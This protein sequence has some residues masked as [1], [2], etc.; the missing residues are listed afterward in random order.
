MEPGPEADNP[1]AIGPAG[2]VHATLADWGKYV[3]LHVAGDRA[4]S[5]KAP[6]ESAKLLKPA[7]FAKLHTPGAEGADYAMGWGIADRDWGGGRVLTHSGSNTMWFCT[8]W[9]AP[10]RDFVVLVATNQGDDGARAGCDEAAKALI[11]A[12]LA[13]REAEKK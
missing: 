1:P 8:V 12:V 2:T 10:E 7:T 13:R 6:A 11:D 4:A 9:A 5:G 3:A